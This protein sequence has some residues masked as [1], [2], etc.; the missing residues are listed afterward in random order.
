MNTQPLKYACTEQSWPVTTWDLKMKHSQVYMR[1]LVLLVLQNLQ[2][3][4]DSPFQWMNFASSWS[5]ISEWQW[6][7]RQR[8]QDLWFITLLHW[9]SCET[10]LFF[11]SS[12]SRDVA[13]LHGTKRQLANEY[14]RKFLGHLFFNI[15]SET[16]LF[17]NPFFIFEKLKDFDPL[18][19][20]ILIRLMHNVAWCTEARKNSRHLIHWISFKRNI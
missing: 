3:F 7:K 1:T 16:V 19:Y 17:V 20:F 9:Q 18:Q 15:F 6:P 2:S 12:Y 10:L 4:G 13:L 14:R 5:T 8:D 11:S